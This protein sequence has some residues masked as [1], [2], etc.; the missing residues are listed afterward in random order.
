MKQ[1]KLTP[2]KLTN[3]LVSC[4]KENSYCAFGT[5]ESIVKSYN[6]DLTCGCNKV[7]LG[8]ETNEKIV[9]KDIFGKTVTIQSCFFNGHLDAVISYFDKKEVIIKYQEKWIVLTWAKLKKNK[10]FVYAY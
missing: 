5:S 2:A 1:L 7:T 4:Y 8:I 3:F 6:A 9:A 10:V